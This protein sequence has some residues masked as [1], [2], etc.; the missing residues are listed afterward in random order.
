MY[1]SRLFRHFIFFASSSLLIASSG[2]SDK[3]QKIEEGKQ[4]FSA[5]FYDKSALAF[6]EAIEL[7]PKDTEAHYQLAE[8]LTKLGDAQNAA[9]QYLAVLAEDP[10]NDLARL[11]LG[12]LLLSVNQ[13][14]NAEKLALELRAHD[15]KNMNAKILLANV[16]LVK[17]NT[18][19]AITELNSVISEQPDNLHANLLLA[20]IQLKSGRVDQG[21][22]SL[23]KISEKHPDDVSALSLL[24]K[25]YLQSNAPDKALPLLESIIKVEPKKLEHRKTLMLYLVANKK[26]DE[27]E[28]VL[29]TAT[30][31][32]TGDVNA[33]ILLLDFLYE[34]RSPEV[35]MAELLPLIDQSPDNAD[36]RFEL[37]KL[38]LAQNHT[39]KAEQAL[40]EIVDLDKS[41]PNAFKA[42]IQLSK[43]FLATQRINEAKTLNTQLL[44][45]HPKDLESIILRGQLALAEKRINNAITD[46]RQ[47]L[48]DQPQNLA[49]L[50]LI[51]AAHLQN[52]DPVL[53]KENLQKLLAL[54]PNDESV[55]V[56][57]AN[58]LLKTG[59]NEQ[60]LQLIEAVVKEH[61]KSKLALQGA[62]SVYSGQKQW[63]KA[64]DFAKRMQSA[65]PEEGVGYYLSGLAYQAEGKIDA[66]VKAFELALT[67]QPDA[68][69]P[70]TQLIKDLI[71]LKQSDK[72]VT[73]LTTSLKQ[74]PK[75]FIFINMLGT[76]YLNDKKF[77]DA[78][79]AFNKASIIKPD[80]SMPYHMLAVTFNAQNKKTDAIQALKLGVTHTK[81]N[82]E[83]V[84]DLANMYNSTGEHEKA[85]ATYEEAYKSMPDSLD[86][87]NNLIINLSEFG[88]DRAAL[89]KADKLSEPLKQLDN[90]YSRDTLGW[91]NYKLGNY[92]KAQDILQKVITAMPDSP[93]SNYHMGMIYYQLKQNDKAIEYLQKAID[94]NANF[95][96]LSTAKETLAS[97]VKAKH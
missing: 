30:E 25:I 70:M 96:G 32:L 45:S 6:K 65:F 88:K 22:A 57:L 26:V 3:S 27:A 95:Y 24:A 19:N 56:E 63:D 86:L 77:D 97:L 35:A 23:L 47:V 84:N 53:A 85:I 58:V 42:H 1:S 64:Q 79:S 50:K 82:P 13:V 52:N 41:S 31:D 46:F 17:N 94:K 76:V 73:T 81:N 37:V 11:H 14:D 80:W 91:L 29:R 87:L 28:H 2:C 60:A 89:E 93:A 4:L 40:K 7:D 10:K 67:K 69:E 78:I 75:N 16:Q 9:N 44:E 43:L 12:Q 36:L 20:T 34:K 62:F 66:S 83:L 54:T 90:S 68:I 33:K 8:A 49:V 92:S 18:D 21:I 61:P 55:A 59:A 39:D 74:Q 48:V 15:A 51:S 5:G 71:S 38:E 72:A